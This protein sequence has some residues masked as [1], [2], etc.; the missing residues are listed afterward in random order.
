M[1]VLANVA[2]SDLVP[3]WICEVVSPTSGRLDRVHKMPVYAREGVGHIW[4]VDPLQR[5]L[6]VYCLE[7][8]RW[9]LLSTHGDVETVRVE[10]FA[11]LE[12]DLSRW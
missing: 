9:V 1:P 5:T 3:D 11:A 4:L 6:E 8:Q 12:I 10:P 2:Y 7:G